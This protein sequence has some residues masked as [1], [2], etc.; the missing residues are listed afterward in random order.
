MN[1][2]HAW[3]VVTVPS[4]ED[5]ATLACFGIFVVVALVAVIEEAFV[6]HVEAC[7][8]PAQVSSPRALFWLRLLFGRARARYVGLLAETRLPKFLRAP[9]YRLFAWMYGCSLDEVRDPL[10]SYASLADF[11]CRSLKDGARPIASVPEG[12]VSPV[13][14]RLM[15]TGIIDRPD[16]RVQQV[17]GATYS[18]RGFL[19]LDPVSKD[20]ATTVRYAVI[21]L[22]PG[23]YHQ[24]HAP[25]E[26]TLDRG[27]HFSGEL[28]PVGGGILGWM[29]DVFSVNERVILSGSWR[30][31]RM[32]LAAVGAANVGNI[33]LNFDKTLTTNQSR[34]LTVHCGGDVASRVYSGGVQLSAGDSVGGFR[35]GSTV[36]LVFDTPEGFEWTVPLGGAVRLGQPLGEVK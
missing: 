5:A 8:N 26:C 15:T 17:K 11:F 9:L 6:R 2:P 20:P 30:F 1:A 18:V 29:H 22:R 13:D 27:T 16:A 4:L 33:Y 3:P 14:G 31:G 24:V 7:G 34:D 28:L 21:Y 12:L 25:C 10:E 36:V 32:H 19:G 35:L 23:D